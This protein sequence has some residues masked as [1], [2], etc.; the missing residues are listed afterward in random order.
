MLQ[1]NSWR[2]FFTL[3]IWSLQLTSKQWIFT[4]QFTTRADLFLK[5]N[6]FTD[7]VMVLIACNQMLCNVQSTLGLRFDVIARLSLSWGRGSWP[8]CFSCIC[9]ARVSF[10]LFSLTLGVGVG[11]GFWFWHSL[12][13]F[14]NFFLNKCSCFWWR[15]FL[16]NNFTQCRAI[17]NT[18][19]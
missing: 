8:M 3:V 7:G 13:F 18:I 19:Y 16:K 4:Q 1:S 6:V 17:R 14:I 2:D 10:C 5:H 9:F 12:D 15:R 11:Y